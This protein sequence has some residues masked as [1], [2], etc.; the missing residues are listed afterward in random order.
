MTI[1]IF[2]KNNGVDLFSRKNQGAKADFSE[3]QFIYQDMI[4]NANA[5]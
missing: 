1:F 3:K 5:A 2:F 4:H